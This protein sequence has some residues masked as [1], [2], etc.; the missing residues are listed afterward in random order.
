M[1]QFRFGV[2]M[3]EPFPGQTWTQSALELEQLGYDTVFVPE[4]LERQPT[5]KVLRSVRSGQIS[6]QRR[7]RS[8]MFT[9]S[10]GRFISRSMRGLAC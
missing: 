4:N 7:I 8:S 10:A 5:M 9:L 3:K 2:E 6:R 1:R